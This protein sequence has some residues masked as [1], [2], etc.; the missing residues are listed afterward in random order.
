VLGDS[1]SAAYGMD[2][3]RGWVHLLRERLRNSPGEFRVVNASVSGETTSG[4]L[5]R[6]P[7][8]LQRHRPAWVILELGGNDGLRGLPLSRMESNLA[9]MVRL[10]REAGA[11]VLLVGM[12]LPPNYGPVYTRS[13]ET[14]YRKLA[15]ESG[16]PLVPFLLEGVAGN[17]RMM[18]PDNIHA[19]PAAQEKLLDNVWAV[20]EPLISGAPNSAS[21]RREH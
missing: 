20:L 3:S 16:A 1:L 14:V 19:A 21:E 13:F 6:L 17:E 7:G 2:T 4:G 12:K 5:A 9:A 15:R 8:L 10:A 11:G 18:Q